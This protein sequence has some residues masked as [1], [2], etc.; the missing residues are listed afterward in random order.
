M[1]GMLIKLGK[2]EVDLLDISK[3]LEEKATII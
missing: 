1:M 3:K 2:H